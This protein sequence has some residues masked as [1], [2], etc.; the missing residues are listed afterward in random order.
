[1][2][3]K[4]TKVLT[5]DVERNKTIVSLAKTGE[6]SLQAIGDKFNLSRERVRQILCDNG[7]NIKDYRTI[8]S[9]LTPEFLKTFST[10][11]ELVEATG[12]SRTSCYK[13]CV[14]TG[15][16]LKS[17][18]RIFIEKRDK[19][20][21]DLLDKGYTQ[22]EV[23]EKFNMPYSNVSRISLSKGMKKRRLVGE[24]GRKRDDAVYKDFLRGVSRKS[25][26]E[27]YSLKEANLNRIIWK[28]E[29]IQN[30]DEA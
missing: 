26:C 2:K 25:L 8:Q 13:A 20:I 28:M 22:K 14:R 11:D 17:K 21:L 23:A 3:H 9:K 12:Y 19:E 18:K 16:N 29:K 27:K 4:V 6:Y 24:E 7:I 15:I 1:M 30:A 10:L 5:K